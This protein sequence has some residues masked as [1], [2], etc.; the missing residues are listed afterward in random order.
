MGNLGLK[1]PTFS[2]PNR[3]SAILSNI[4]THRMNCFNIFHFNDVLGTA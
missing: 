2:G 4:Y 3:L 1:F